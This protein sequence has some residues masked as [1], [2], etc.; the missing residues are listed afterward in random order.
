[1][2]S[3]VLGVIMPVLVCFP[4]SHFQMFDDDLT[5]RELWA[6]GYG[7]FL[8]ISGG[9]LLVQGIGLYRG[10]SWSRWL[11]VFQYIFI[12]PLVVIY[13]FHHDS[14]QR[15][16]VMQTL[17]AGVIWAAFSYWYLFHKQKNQFI[18]EAV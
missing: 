8:V 3:T 16:L 11:V 6:Q 14:G 15:L 7:P 9:E 18:V 4:S 10:I 2:A 1:M 12:V 13:L 5:G 17:V